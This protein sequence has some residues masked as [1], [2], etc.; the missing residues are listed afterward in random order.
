M[1]IGK[2][3]SSRLF[4]SSFLVVYKTKNNIFY[5]YNKTCLQNDCESCEFGNFRENFYSSSRIVLKDIFVTLKFAT[6]W[7][8]LTIIVND[9]VISPFREN[10]ALA[11]NPK[12][13][14]TS[15]VFPPVLSQVKEMFCSV[16]F[17]SI[18]FC[19]CAVLSALRVNTN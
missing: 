6:I 14:Y 1:I 3:C 11:K 8:D 5:V 16:P 2:K 12:L 10:K 7:Y 13:E 17:Y 4:R 19:K 15:L 9:R 18:L